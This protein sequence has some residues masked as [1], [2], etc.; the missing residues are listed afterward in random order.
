MKTTGVVRRI[1]ELGRIVIPKEIRKN[2]RI[3]NGDYLE[4]FIDDDKVLLDK[5]SPMKSISEIASKYC[6]SFYQI[7]KHNIIVTDRDKILA[8]TGSL[9]KKYINCEISDII[10]SMIER[11][12]NFI[13]NKKKNIYLTADDYEYGYYAFSSIINNGDAIGSVIILS[14]DNPIMETE[15][16]MASIMA[17]LLSGE[18]IN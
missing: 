4:I 11:R 1:D 12:D 3:N 5:Y 7:L 13:E 17:K 15:E 9:R 2:L 14:L 10:K 16:K 18:F 8:I 6:D